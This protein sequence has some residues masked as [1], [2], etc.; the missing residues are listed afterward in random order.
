MKII[1]MF[2]KS[3]KITISF[4]GLRI[5]NKFAVE[6]KK[7]CLLFLNMPNKSE[8]VNVDFI[9]GY[10]NGNSMDDNFSE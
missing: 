8:M 9:Y 5:N 2:Y 6:E 10:I 7:I 4:H 3:D 1:Q